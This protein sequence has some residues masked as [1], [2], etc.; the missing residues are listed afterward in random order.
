MQGVSRLYSAEYYRSVLRHLTPRGCMSQRLPV[1]QLPPQATRLL[2]S[3]FV[4]AFPYTLL[5]V[6]SGA[7]LILVGSGSPLDLHTLE[8]RFEADPAVLGDLH[9]IGVPTPLHLLSRVLMTD[10]QLRARFGGAPLSPTRRPS[11]RRSCT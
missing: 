7:E 10:R 2:V 6:G 4:D 3:T 11:S 5:L 8:G 1:Y 9:D